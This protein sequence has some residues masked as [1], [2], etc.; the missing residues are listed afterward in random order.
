MMTVGRC[1]VL[2]LGVL[3]MPSAGAQVASAERGGALYENHCVVC[4]T[5]NVHT[6]VN[7]LPVSRAQVREIVDNWQAQQ[8]LTWGAQEVED[9]VEYL[10]R[11]RYRFP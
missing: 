2:T 7:R 10:N 5:S 1:C 8:K 4:H 9:V 3:L 11:T 6:R